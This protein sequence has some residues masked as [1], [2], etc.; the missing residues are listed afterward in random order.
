MLDIIGIFV[1]I[2]NK[3]STYHIFM[4]IFNSLPVISSTHLTINEY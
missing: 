4:I 3:T 2:L 1:Y